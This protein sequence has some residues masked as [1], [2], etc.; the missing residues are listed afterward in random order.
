MRYVKSSSDRSAFLTI[1][2][3]F[4]KRLLKR[5]YPANILDKW[6]DSVDYKNRMTFI[7]N[8]EDGNEGEDVFEVDLER[9]EGECNNKVSKLPLIYKVQYNQRLKRLSLSSIF[10]QT[11]NDHRGF[12]ESF[13]EV[14]EDLEPIV[15]YT[16][17]P[18]LGQTIIRARMK[19]SD[20][21]L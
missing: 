14:T 2:H 15:C 16:R 20:D 17:G 11:V 4:Y 9:E 21:N 7:F 10:K 3:L 8:Q 5:D 12:S 18:K 13:K 1:A 6:F 19:I